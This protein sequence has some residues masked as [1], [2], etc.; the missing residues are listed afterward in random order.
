MFDLESFYQLNITLIMNIYQ[1]KAARLKVM[2]RQKHA[3]MIALFVGG[4]PIVF[5]TKFQICERQ[6]MKLKL[7]L[8]SQ[9]K[10]LELNY[11]SS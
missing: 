1:E 10:A 3:H 9:V 11:H 6:M 8:L 4:D 5:V 2:M 7:T